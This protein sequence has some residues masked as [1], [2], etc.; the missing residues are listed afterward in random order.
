M[1]NKEYQE[2]LRANIIIDDN[3]CWIWQGS[4]I[5]KG[6][7]QAKDLE[8][9]RYAHRNSFTVFKGPIPEG[10][11]VRHTC[12]IM[13]CINPEHLIPG[14]DQDNVDDMII[15]GRKGTCK[16]VTYMRTVTEE[17][18]EGIRQMAD[19]GY[20]YQQIA[21]HYGISKGY[22]WKVV[23]GQFRRSA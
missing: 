14:T 23:K 22:A 10:K 21:D 13:P 18:I 20:N 2:Y 5:A 4:I 15:R 19:E 12:D 17:A 16:G 8:G 11:L 1:D 6:Y 9:D 7:G 3:G